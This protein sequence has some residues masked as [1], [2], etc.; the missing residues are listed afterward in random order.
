[1]GKL[2]RVVIIMAVIILLLVAIMVSGGVA[3]AKDTRSLISAKLAIEKDICPTVK[4]VIREN[5][6]ASV[7]VT[8]AI[9]MGHSACTVVKCAIEEGASLEQVI[10]GAVAAGASP[11]VIS[12]CCTEAGARP[13]EV[14]AI[15][16]REEFGGLGYTPPGS[17][18]VAI[19]FPGGGRSG[20]IYISPSGF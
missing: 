7:V 14:A 6:T 15:L 12:R 16:A 18:P 19:G 8:T 10:F 11:D 2:E 20:G 13:A 17:P 5:G 4:S 3:D 1:M 9:Q